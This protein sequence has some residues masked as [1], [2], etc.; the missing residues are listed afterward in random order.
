LPGDAQA[1]L[2]H[3]Q[4]RQG[5]ENLFQNPDRQR[6]RFLDA[7]VEHEKLLRAT[8][9]AFNARDIDT[10]LRQ[11]VADVDWP[12]A[13]EGG[14]VHGHQGVRDYWTRQRS[15]IDPAV[16]PVA[17]T[18]RSDGS[19]AVEVDQVARGLDGTLLGEGRVL[20]V[21]VFRDDLIARMD[22]EELSSAD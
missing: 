8:Y 1:P 14:R 13:W 2:C 21:Y 3:T 20:H 17:F 5:Q 16:E 10:V 11:M 19:I 22:V 6:P 12:S 18:K 4:A 9:E 7:A 15:A